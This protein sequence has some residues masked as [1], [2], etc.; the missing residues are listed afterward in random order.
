[1]AE[2]VSQMR[3]VFLRLVER[4]WKSF[5]KDDGSTIEGGVSRRM[6]VLPDEGE[7]FSLRIPASEGQWLREVQ[8]LSLGDRIDLTVCGIPVVVGGKPGM[9]YELRMLG[10]EMAYATGNG[11]PTTTAAESEEPFASSDSPALD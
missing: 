1:M 6:W 10:R 2:L 11:Q 3:P 9:R 4:E 8:S 5:T 7:P